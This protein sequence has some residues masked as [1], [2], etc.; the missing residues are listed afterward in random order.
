[1]LDIIWDIDNLI[2]DSAV[3]RDMLSDN[4][5]QY[6]FGSIGNDFGIHLIASFKYAENDGFAACTTPAFA[7]D[8]FCTEIG[9]VQ[10]YDAVKRRLFFT[11]E[12][13]A[14]PK[15][16]EQAVDTSD[17]DAREFGGIGSGQI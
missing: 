8:T 2:V 3:N 12:H 6:G 5:L 1:M 15:F 17:A 16:Q 4:L 11:L 10:F 13:H 7:S 9:F 14:P